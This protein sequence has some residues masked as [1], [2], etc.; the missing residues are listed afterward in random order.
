M[1][2][3]NIAT[4]ENLVINIPAEAEI[5]KLNNLYCY[6][7][8]DLVNVDV[9]LS[10]IPDI[11]YLTIRPYSNIKNMNI[12]ISNCINSNYF[13]ISLCGNVEQFN[14]NMANTKNINYLNI[15]SFNLSQDLDINLTSCININQL[16][17]Y[18]LKGDN[19]NNLTI[20]L[21]NN[22]TSINRMLI[23]G[24]SIN[25][26]SDL[27]YINIKYNGYTNIKMNYISFAYQSKLTDD[28][29]DNLLGFLANINFT[30]S[31]TNK[32]LSVVF[33]GCGKTQEYFSAL[34]NYSNLIAKGWTC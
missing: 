16:Y 26:P 14:I 30:G 19:F 11:P 12:D 28:C 22:I 21:N 25:N 34:S 18:N 33:S 6:N 4:L 29:F 8:I 5:Y 17:L 10:K 7:C 32:K 15:S 27:S 24:A 23:F 2:F 13:E 20:T 3:S 1:S 31:V 9:N